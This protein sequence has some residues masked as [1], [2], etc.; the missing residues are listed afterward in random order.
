MRE[1]RI[2]QRYKKFGAPWCSWKVLES[3]LDRNGLRHYRLCEMKD[4][5]IIKLVSEHALANPRFYQ[6]EEEV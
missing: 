5:S 6:L 4:P 2:R 1:I 3:V